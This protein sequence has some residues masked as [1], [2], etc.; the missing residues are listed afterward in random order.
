MDFVYEIQFEVNG[1]SITRVGR[2]LFYPSDAAF[3]LEHMLWLMT[4]EYGR[5]TSIT[6]HMH[7]VDADAKM[8]TTG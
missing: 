4:E 1:M 3:Q 8:I 2:G 6:V 7:F 5:P